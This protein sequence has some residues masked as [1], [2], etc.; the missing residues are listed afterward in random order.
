MDIKNVLPL[1][2]DEDVSMMLDRLLAH[3]YFTATPIDDE[4]NID[5]QDE[6]QP[7]LFKGQAKNPEYR[8]CFG[9]LQ[10]ASDIL[11]KMNLP[12]KEEYDALGTLLNFVETNK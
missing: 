5:Q 6:Q 3:V 9:T 2:S 12:G 1:E 7:T 10:L 8:V 11:E 4:F